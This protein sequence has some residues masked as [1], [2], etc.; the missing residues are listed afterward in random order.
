M[1]DR[2]LE[3]RG[4][5]CQRHPGERRAVECEHGGRNYTRNSGRPLAIPGHGVAAIIA[6]VDST[7]HTSRRLRFA[8]GDAAF[9]A[10]T[11][12]TCA[13]TTANIIRLTCSTA[14]NRATGSRIAAPKCRDRLRIRAQDEVQREAEQELNVER[15][16]QDQPPAVGARGSRRHHDDSHEAGNERYPAK[17]RMCSQ[18]ELI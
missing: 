4:N 9:L 7:T 11:R 18:D 5:N 1:R 12:P 14:Q 3:D 13:I 8:A 6:R 10:S 2:D 15:D 16:H 17:P